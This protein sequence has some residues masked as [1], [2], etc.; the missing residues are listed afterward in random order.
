MQ[1]RVS[2]ASLPFSGSPGFC[3]GKSPWTPDCQMNAAMARISSSSRRKVGILVPSRQACGS[4]SHTGI[5]S[6]RSFMRTSLRLGPTFFTSRTSSCERMSSC[7]ILASRPLE[8]TLRSLACWKSLR[9]SASLVRRIVGL[10]FAEPDFAQPFGLLL[11]ELADLLVHRGDLVGVAVEAFVAVAAH[12]AA[13]AEDLA[14]LVEGVGHLGDDL[15]RRGTA[16]SRPRCSP[17]GAAATAS[18]CCSRAPSPRWRA[19][20]RC[21]RGRAC[22][23]TSRDRGSSAAPCW[24]GW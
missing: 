6:L 10:L 21:R 3:C 1:P 19:P 18:T 15:F 9:A 14:A 5:H 13:Q 12:A 7:S 20:R 17:C 11:L 24:D 23:R 16:G 22:S 2:K 8:R 4:F